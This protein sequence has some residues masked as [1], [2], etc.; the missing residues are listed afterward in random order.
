MD[1]ISNSINI[2]LILR[3]KPIKILKIAFKVQQPIDLFFEVKKI[4][5]SHIVAKPVQIIA[6]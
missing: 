4:F 1:F 3:T 5:V 2:N 6:Y